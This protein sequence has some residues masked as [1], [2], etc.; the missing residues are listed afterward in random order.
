[1]PPPVVA[2]PVAAAPVVAAAAA[3]VPSALDVKIQQLSLEAPT[4]GTIHAAARF[5]PE[6][7]ATALRKAMKGVGTVR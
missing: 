1:V 6:T 2:A 3:H 5:D 7:D 4:Q